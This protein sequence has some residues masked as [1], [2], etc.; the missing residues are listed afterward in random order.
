[1]TDLAS[2]PTP[3]APVAPGQYA[4]ETTMSPWR[5]AFRYGAM[6]LFLA[7][8]MGALYAYVQGADVD[9]TAQ[10]ALTSDF[11]WSRTQRHIYL[12]VVSTVFVIL[13]AMP[14]GILSTRESAKKLKPLFISMANAGQAVPSLGFITLIV[15]A[16]GTGVRGVVIGLVAYSAL[17]ILRNTIAGLE[18][19]DA[20]L[21][22]SARGMGMS[23][24]QVLRQIELPLA[25]P[26]VVAGVRVALI[27]NV[28]TAALAFLFGAGGLGEVI[29]TGFQLR[30]TVVLVTGSVLVSSLALFI[31]YLAGVAED[32]LTPR[33]L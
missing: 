32:V 28:G 27:L 3:D 8:V 13:I 15:I 33:G 19:V 23:R 18:A 16:I 12:A 2:A 11:L 25:V 1:M 7:V 9:R 17:P 31:D 4:G 5:K 20:S 6:P 10:R 30:R 22:E 14:L 21:I 29:F 24:L 26:V